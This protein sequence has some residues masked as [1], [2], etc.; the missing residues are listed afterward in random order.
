MVALHDHSGEERWL[1]AA[2]RAGRWLAEGVDSSG[3]WPQQDYRAAGTPSYYT[4]AAWPMLEVAVRAD[5][6]AIRKAA[7][8]V[9]DAIL[10]RR[11]PN[12]AFGDWGFS[13]GEAAFTHTIAYTLQGFISSALL[14]GEWERYGE[15]VEQGLRELARLAEPSRGKLP[16]R[17]DDEWKP[18]ARYVCLTGNVQTALCILDRAEA[19]SDSSLDAVAAA[20]TDAVCDTQRLRAPLPSLRGAVGGSAPI[21][22]RYMILRY[23][24]WAAKYHCDAMMRLMARPAATG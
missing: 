10:A 19:R 8:G 13:P 15:P 24:N 21:W 17:V 7:L 20:L 16:G 14:L 5:D 12:G 18:A 9:L 22:G 2:V 1:E 6:A 23:P 4:Y 3:L 11:R